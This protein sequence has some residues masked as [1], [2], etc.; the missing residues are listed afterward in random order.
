MDVPHVFIHLPTNEHL[1]Y[2]HFLAIVSSILWFYEHYCLYTCLSPCFQFFQIH[3]QERGH[4]SIC[5]ILYKTLGKYLSVF[6]AML[7]CL[8]VL[9]E[10]YSLP[11]L[12][13]GK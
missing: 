2:F 12:L 4:Y 3:A 1:S 8:A 6:I 7:S 13:H 11:S 9:T 5:L 10:N